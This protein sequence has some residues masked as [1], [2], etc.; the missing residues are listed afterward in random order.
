[1][2]ADYA[3]IRAILG[4]SPANIPRIGLGGSNVGLDWRVLGFT[5][6]L[7]ILTGVLFGLVPALQSSRA[8]LSSTLKES[9]SR[10]GTGLRHN[11]TAPCW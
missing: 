7:S 4:V 2:A 6:A 10:S 9:G 11:K 8:D 5:L 3:G 1:L